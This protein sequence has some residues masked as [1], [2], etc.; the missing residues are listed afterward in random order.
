LPAKHSTRP[1]GTARLI[2]SAGAAVLVMLVV[3]VAM[4]AVGP[5]EASRQPTV[6]LPSMPQMPITSVGVPSVAP[7]PSPTVSASPSVTSAS[8]TSTSRS[9]VPEKTSKSH[10]PTPTPTRT[11]ATTPPAPPPPPANDLAVAVTVGASWEQG[12][13]AGVRIQNTGRKSANWT[14]TVTHSNLSNFRLVGTWG[15]RGTQQG[16]RV[17]FTGGPLAAGATV[18][19]GYQTSKT[20]RGNARPSGCTVVGGTCGVR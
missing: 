4:R 16:D 15:A 12:Y 19:F 20:G 14:V 11:R 1:L 17:V 7:S 5:A 8:P 2:F 18:N 13:V 3:W 10:S 6:V 9:P